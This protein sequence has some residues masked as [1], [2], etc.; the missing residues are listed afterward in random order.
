MIA[1]K[2]LYGDFLLITPLMT[3]LR[4]RRRR[5][6]VVLSACWF[7]GGR[8]PSLLSLSLS[9]THQLHSVLFYTSHLSSSPFSLQL[10]CAVFSLVKK[11]PMRRFFLHSQF[12]YP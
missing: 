6:G 4:I 1:L 8:A 12:H 9:Q 7:I 3:L 10:W 5:G 2:K 11:P